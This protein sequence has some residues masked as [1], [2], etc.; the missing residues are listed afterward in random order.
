MV[1]TDF[2]AVSTATDVSL[3]FGSATTSL[4]SI[5][6]SYQSIQLTVTVSTSLDSA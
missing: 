3:T 6:N 5:T 2:P 4:S 1:V